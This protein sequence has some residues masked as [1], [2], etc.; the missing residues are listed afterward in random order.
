MNS[1]T[2]IP[3]PSSIDTL[4]DLINIFTTGVIRPVVILAFL[5]GVIYGGWT[6]LTAGDD[7]KKVESSKK[8]IT[9][10]AIGFA[11]IAFAPI[12]V[13]F[14]GTLLGVRGGLLDFN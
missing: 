13:E 5:A 10:S 4:E 8:I 6:Y 1:I 12:I 7:D 11:I 2:S 14:I 9:A 3:N